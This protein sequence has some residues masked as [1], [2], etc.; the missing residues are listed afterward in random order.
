[1]ALVHDLRPAPLHADAV[2][3]GQAVDNLVSNALKFTERGGTVRVE[4]EPPE[5]GG[6]LV[7]VVDSGI[8]I[9]P[10]E[11]ARLTER[12]YRATTATRRAIPGVGLGLSITKAVVEAHGGTVTVESTV[13]EG[14]CFTLALPA[15]PPR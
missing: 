4:V 7:R 6:A 11:L 8:G 2:R 5:D 12:F 14:T 1:M 9:P 3:L 10:D 15:R 13:G